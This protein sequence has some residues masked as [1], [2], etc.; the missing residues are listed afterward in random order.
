LD[1]I[2]TERR[3][4]DVNTREHDRA[5]QI[6]LEAWRVLAWAEHDDR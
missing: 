6:G 1:R 2:R 5:D 4:A 3:N